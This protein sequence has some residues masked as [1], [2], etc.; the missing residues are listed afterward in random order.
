MIHRSSYPFACLLLRS[1]YFDFFDSPIFGVNVVSER[2]TSLQVWVN[3]CRFIGL[4]S[5]SDGGAIYYSS[6]DIKMVVEQCLF[7]NCDAGSRGGC[8][9]FSSSGKSGIVLSKCYASKCKS[10][11]STSQQS[12]SFAYISVNEKSRN[13][14]LWVSYSQCASSTYNNPEQ[15][16]S[17]SDGLVLYANDNISNN[18]AYQVSGMKLDGLD[19][20]SIIKFSNIA[21][22]N[23]TNYYCLTFYSSSIVFKN[24]N[25]INNTEGQPT[26]SY[27]G[28]IFCQSSSIIRFEDSVFIHN[29]YR[30]NAFLFRRT[31][32]YA[33]LAVINC[34]LPQVFNQTLAGIVNH[35]GQT[36]THN[37]SFFN[38]FAE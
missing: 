14:L 12:G 34:W 15:T 7:K 11:Q 35:R 24:I 9:H 4:A 20:G 27:Y 17:V 36:E 3:D 8:I 18:L 26:S 37:I 13:E 33:G 32:G 5:S 25:F 23:A 10:S 19:E 21:H 1:H 16:L 6:S 31:T 2:V 30:E 28:I 29:D 38:T 22:N